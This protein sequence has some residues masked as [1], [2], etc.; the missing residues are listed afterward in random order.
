VVWY[1]TH[2]HNFS[3]QLLTARATKPQ[4]SANAK[5]LTS[6]CSKKATPRRFPLAV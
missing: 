6:V 1:P 2:H 3:T 4:K 5:A